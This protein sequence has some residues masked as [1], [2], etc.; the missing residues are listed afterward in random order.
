MKKRDNMVTYDSLLTDMYAAHG[1]I[2]TVL[3]NGKRVNEIE[4]KAVLVCF[5][6][7]IRVRQR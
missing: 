7:E 5:E 3:V 1:Y 6:C 2:L 4:Y